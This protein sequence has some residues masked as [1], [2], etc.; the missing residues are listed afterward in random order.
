[1]KRNLWLKRSILIIVIGLACALILEGASRLFLA[2]KGARPVVPLNTVQFDE[3][4]GWSHVPLSQGVSNRTGYPTEYRINSKGL[5]DDETTY[6]KSEGTFRIVL[7]GDSFTF[8]WG[9][10]IEKHY[11]TLLE[12]YFKNVEV[13]NMGIEAFGVDQELLYLRLEGLRYEPDL[14][15]AYVPGYFEHRHMHTNRFGR[16]K[17]RFVLNDGELVL[18]NSPVQ[19]N[20]NTDIRTEINDWLVRNSKA[21]NILFYGLSGLIKRI[22][23]P[24]QS[25][26][27]NG[28]NSADEQFTREMHELGEAIILAMHKDSL[29]HGAVFVLV[30][31]V[32]ELHQA[33]LEKQIPSLNVSK[34]LSNGAYRLPE[35]LLHINESGNGALAWEISRFLQMNHLI[36]AEHLKFELP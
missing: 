34:S 17:P 21:Y 6:E 30:T 19:D 5:R 23:S 36:P 24:S 18:K 29:E 11:S 15:L 12:G 14:V 2:D 33:A 35:N 28:M 13:I 4:L 27:Q 1:V 9:V 16:N 25:N 20:R 26:S 31:Q 10:P 8:G 22:K 3:R 7:L 32:D